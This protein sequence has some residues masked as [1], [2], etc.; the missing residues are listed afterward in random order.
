M[1]VPNWIYITIFETQMQS[2]AR[3]VRVAIL[4]ALR[5]ANN[6]KILHITKWDEIVQ[7]HSEVCIA[8]LMT[9]QK[10][11]C[12]YARCPPNEG[13]ATCDIRFEKEW[14]TKIRTIK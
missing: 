2:P 10:Q 13:S 5:H 3:E 9:M 8:V 6:L 11:Y 12:V 4:K 14:K 1:G 7:E